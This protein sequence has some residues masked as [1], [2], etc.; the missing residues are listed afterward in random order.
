MNSARI[1]A[2]ELDVT[3]DLH[4]PR[5][6]LREA[7]ELAAHAFGAGRT[8]FLVNG[9]S[10]GIFAMIAANCMAGQKLLIARDFHYSAF[11]A[12]RFARVNPVYIPVSG[13]GVLSPDDVEKTLNEHPG[14]AA[15][16][17][18]RPGY[19]GSICDISEITRLAHMRGVPVLVDEAHGAHFKFSDRLPICALD[20]GADFCVQSA[21][22]TLPAFTQCA[23][24]HAS[25]KT[26]NRESAATERFSQ[27]LRTF[28][29]SSPSFVL[30]A[31]LDYAR[32]YM[33]GQGAAELD[34]VLDNCE[35]FYIS[36]SDSGYGIPHDIWPQDAKP[37]AGRGKNGTGSEKHRYG[38]DM[39]RLVLNTKPL[40]LSGTQAE[41][42]LWSR[43][44]IKIEMSDPT[45]IV[46]IATA[47]DSDGDFA[48][49]QSALKEIANAQ[50]AGQK[51]NHIIGHGARHM[52][53]QYTIRDAG[54]IR[55]ENANHDFK[56][57][58][59]HD[60]NID[61]ISNLHAP[62]RFIPLIN[63]EGRTAADIVAPYPP[64]IPLLCPGEII[65]GRA[66]A[67]MLSLLNEGRL[68]KGVQPDDQSIE[69]YQE[70]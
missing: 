10:C 1:D 17:L 56:H 36:M 57:A 21:H 19:Y 49:L 68:I 43:Y 11:N 45:H 55:T 9:S 70:I 40:G 5:G 22:K 67:E 20:G 13:D 32:E 66:I 2:T 62:K 4:S 44:D 29:T 37:H 12:M 46:M 6:P 39:A 47:A 53:G 64:G 33:S 42:I 52:A 25:Y 59:S 50:G 8:W 38:R 65:T 28:Q 34:R 26:A 14:A 58:V 24:A 3:D 63:A 51:A 7:Q 69:V 61:F 41:S 16:Y 60:I 54:S 30:A 18:T 31:S 48:A 35:S 27:A 15:L 23:Y